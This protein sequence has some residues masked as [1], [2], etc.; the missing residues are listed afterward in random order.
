[1]TT[2][3]CYGIEEI[4]FKEIKTTKLH[5]IQLKQ[6]LVQLWKITEWN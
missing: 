3:N 5:S 2:K 4:A 1:M 6:Y